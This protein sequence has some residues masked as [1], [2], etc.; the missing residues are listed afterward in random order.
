MN[1]KELLGKYEDLMAVRD[2]V[3]KAL[4]LARSQKIIGKSMNANVL[5]YPT[6]KVAK[7]ITTLDVDLKQIFIVSNFNIATSDFDGNEYPSGKIAV[8]AAEGLTCS[9]CWQI[10]QSLNEGELCPRCERIVKHIK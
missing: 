4:E 10:V 6:D 2:D 8:R 7:L 1:A 3:L 5:L 9:R